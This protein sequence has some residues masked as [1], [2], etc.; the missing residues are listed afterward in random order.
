MALIICPDCGKQISDKAVACPD[1]GC[2]ISSLQGGKLR[3]ECVFFG[4]FGNCR[5][6]VNFCGTSKVLKNGFYDDFAVPSDGKEHTATI[7][8]A[9][10][11][12]SATITVKIKSGESKKITVI[13]DDSKVFN[14]WKYR[15]EMFITK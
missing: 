7:Y 11:F 15:E 5:I 13:Y 3:V 10:G 8:C 14:H 4:I 9:K 12:D 1:C 6:T 2:P